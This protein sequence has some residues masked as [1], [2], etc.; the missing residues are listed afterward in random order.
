MY[1]NIMKN[2]KTGKTSLSICRGFRDETG[3]VKHTTIKTLGLLED[4]KDAVS[5][6][7]EVT[8]KICVMSPAASSYNAFKNFE[9][10][11]SAYKTYVKEN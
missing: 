8:K 2:K 1:L 3:K 4:L 11:G 9:E 7:K 5:K 10:K 6:A